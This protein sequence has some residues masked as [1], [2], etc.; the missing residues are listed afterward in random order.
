MRFARTALVATA[1]TGLM[2]VSVPSASALPVAARADVAANTANLTQEV[3]YRRH[4]GYR[5]H[6]RPYRY[7]YYGRRYYGR[8]Y[9]RGYRRPGFGIYLGF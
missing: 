9:Y 5:R 7:G 1:L 8:P 2:Y 6:Y 4:R 3:R